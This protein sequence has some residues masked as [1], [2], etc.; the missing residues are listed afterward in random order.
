MKHYAPPA[1]TKSKKAIF[2][3]VGKVKVTRSLTLMSFEKAPLV[4]NAKKKIQIWN[5]YLL[6]FKGYGEG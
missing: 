3:T 6:R 1:A 4:E 5:L 2:S